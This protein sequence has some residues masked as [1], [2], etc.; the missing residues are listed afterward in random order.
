V[1]YLARR[2]A[3]R[4][5]CRMALPMA[6]GWKHSV[7]LDSAG[8]LLACGKGAAVGPDDGQVFY[9]FPTP[10][11]AM[12]GV[13]VRS[14]AAAGHSL[15]LGWDG[16]VYS[17]GFNEYGQLGHGDKLARPSPVLVEGLVRACSIA[18]FDHGSFAVTQSGEVFSWGGESGIVIS[19][20]DDAHYAGGTEE[21]LRLMMIEGFGRSRIR[22]LC[23]GMHAVF[24][25]GEDGEL[26]SW[27]SL[28]FSSGP[29]HLL[30]HGDTQD[31]ASPK[32][33]EALRGV[34]VSSVAVGDHH[35]VALAEDGLVYAWGKNW[36]RAVLGHPHVE[37]E[38]LPTPIE[39]LRGVRMV[40]VAAAGDRSYAIAR[41]G[42]LWAWGAL[43]PR[44]RSAPP[45][46]PATQSPTPAAAPS[47][48]CLTPPSLLSPPRLSYA[49]LHRPTPPSSPP[50]RH[51]SAPPYSRAA[52]LP[53]PAA[54]RS[55]LARAA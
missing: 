23:A 10:V 48:H 40:S 18:A 7:L 50:P 24:A 12:A 6:A 45:Y 42:E 33:V 46:N 28:P 30:G 25:I 34:R 38:L 53:T 22:Q 1:T 13:R 44:H 49:L 19:D 15:A 37:R 51:R 3:W 14:V 8:R 52:P 41:T 55:C 39:A 26:F 17:W 20:D 11:A 36:Q 29:S 32:R 35:V 5:R 4:R 16:W 31:Q 9:P 21:L 27:R 54:A 47:C 43:P 2:R